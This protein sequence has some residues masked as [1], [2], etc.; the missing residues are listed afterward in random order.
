MKTHSNYLIEFILFF[1]KITLRFFLK[2]DLRLYLEVP[3]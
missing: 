2:K 1:D 3:C